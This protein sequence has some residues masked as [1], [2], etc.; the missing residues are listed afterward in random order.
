[1]CPVFFVAESFT[2]TKERRLH[3][4]TIPREVMLQ[5]VRRDGQICQKCFQPVRDNKVEFDH[6]IPFSRGGT[7]TAGNLRL[8]CF[9]CNRSKGNSLVEILSDNPIEHLQA[10]QKKKTAKG[11]RR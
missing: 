10:I 2:E 8:V 11:K 6:I 3:S 4:R 7:S 5:V 9:D 1:M